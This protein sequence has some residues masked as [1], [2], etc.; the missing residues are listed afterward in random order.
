M[1]RSLHRWLFLAAGALG[2]TAA[3]AE[4]VTEA[5]SPVSDVAVTIY[6]AAHGSAESLDLDELRGFALVTE[7][8]TI[9]IPAGVSR[10]RFEGVADGIQPATAIITGL[11]SGLL[12]KNH[13]AK[14]LSPAELVTATIGK[15]VWLVRTNP[16]TGQSNKVRGSILSDADGVVF[17]SAAGLEA[18]RC[19]GLPEAFQFDSTL[20]GAATP[21]LSALVRSPEAT[22]ATVRLSYLAEG[23]DWMANYVATVAPDGKTLDLGAWVTLANSNS[24]SFS[25][26]HA[27]VVAGRLNRES[28]EVEPV[29]EG[30]QIVAKCWPRGSTSDTPEI[31]DIIAASPLMP[32]WD[33]LVGRAYMKAAAPAAL[34]MDM[35]LQEAV[36]TGARVEQEQLG[37][38]KLYRVPDRTS[39]ASRQI[40]QVRLLDRQAV[41]IDLFYR[42]DIGA[43]EN[44]VT[45]EPLSKILR[46]RNDKAHHLDLPLPSGR[47]ATFY[48]RD[49]VPLLVHEAQLRDI[50]LDEEVEIEAGEAPDLRATSV[51]E[52]R[53]VDVATVKKLP[54]VPGA[55]SLRS[56]DIDATHR[57]EITNARDQSSAVELRLTLNDGTQLA[58]ADHTPFMHNGHQTFRLTV[59]ARGSAV[60]RYQIVDSRY[61]VEPQ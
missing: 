33:L 52:E 29:D 4:G 19:A 39:V 14:V 34:P 36:V 45:D 15:N 55:F 12:E 44:E 26:A 8:R 11:P 17:K 60:V 21:T 30:A 18:L 40:K 22:T 42:A 49:G 43:E 16:K 1:R 38:L 53:K 57:V 13:D 5:A 23:F 25:N 48:E 9:S 20:E 35:A 7:T 59:P 51:T 61:S 28:E 54:L 37:D 46:T 41:P 3:A 31:P 10:L 32:G 47:I 58:R 2:T 24:R 50:T 56:V 27:Q 6:R